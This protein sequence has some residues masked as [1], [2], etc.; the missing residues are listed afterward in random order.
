MHTILHAIMHAFM[1]MDEMVDLYHGITTGVEY[2]VPSYDGG[3]GESITRNHDIRYFAV[4]SR[5]YPVGGL[6]NAQ[7]GYHS[8]NPTGI[9]YAPT[10]LSGLDP[11]MYIQSIYQTQRGEGPVIERTQQ[12]Y[13][14]E[15][16]L[17]I[18]RQQ[19]GATVDLIEA[20]PEIFVVS[21]SDKV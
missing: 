11:N 12:A 2:T 14:E 17:D 18:T 20:A 3:P 1:D 16:L 13:E 10:T 19:S 4:D 21:A 7:A 5:L 15:Y 9:F 6:Y 8:Y